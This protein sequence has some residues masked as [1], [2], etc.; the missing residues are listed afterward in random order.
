MATN[1]SALA[2]ARAFGPAQ[3][4]IGGTPLSPEA[5][6][7]TDGF[8]RACNYLAA[9]MIYLRDNPLLL[10]PLRPEH[11]KKRLLGHWGSSPGLSFVYTHLN[12]VIREYDLDM[13]FLAGPGHGAPGVLAPVY[14]EGSYSDIYPD[15]SQDLHGLQR[16]FLQ[17][18]FPGGIGSHCTPETPGSIHEGGE[19]GYSL[20]HAF[21]AA[22]DNPRLIVAVVVGDGESETG[23]LATSWHGNKFLNPARDGAV[24]PLLHLNGYKINNPTI[25]ARVPVEELASLLR[26]YGWEPLF[27]EGSEPASMHQAMAATLNHAVEEIQ[28]IQTEARR[29][30]VGVRPRWPMIVLRSPKGWTGP[31]S[32]GGHKIEGTWRAHQ[33]P[34]TEVASKPENLKQLEAWLRSYKPE[35][36]FDPDGRLAPELRDLPPQ[37]P[38][39]MG[40]NPHAN[41]G[42]LRRDLRLPDF[43]TYAVPEVK[44]GRTTAENTR[45]LGALL[46]DTLA[47]NPDNFRIFGPDENTSNKLDAAYA[48]TKKCWM[49]EG[50]PDDR[51]GT[52]LAPDG[53]V[54]EMLS[55]HT[56][57]GWF[58]GYLLTGRHG[59]FS[60]Y[61][62]FAHVID[63]MF[64]QHA[65][66]LEIASHL[67]WRADLASLNLLITSTVWR[68]DH[69]GFTHQDPG[70]L[71][72]VVNKSAQVTRI[73]LPPDANCLLSVADHC[74]R[75][76]NY[77]N[78]IVADKQK[79]LQYLDMDAAIRHCTKGVGIWEWASTDAGHDPE[80]VLAAAGDVPTKES[81]AAAALLRQEFPDVKLRFVN[82]VDL[83]R[84]QP[85]SEHPHG[86]SDRDF[87]S[88]FTS[89]RPII[90]AFH[91]YPW[92]IHRLAYRRRNH[93]NL[94]VRGYKEKGNINTPLELAMSNEVDRFSLAIDVIDRVPRLRAVGAHARERFRNQQLDCR[95]HAH[96]EGIDRPSESD[97]IWPF[98][99]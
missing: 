99:P 9:G 92:L 16:F 80:V 49:A 89:D 51:D 1:Q 19:L 24:L 34:L 29:N 73:Y 70:F 93:A 44:P 30:G 61:E 63:S 59:F 20:S 96:A 12:R 46:R 48:V 97:W 25:L 6:A 78:V 68:Q 74:L 11:L 47:A 43:R 32:V 52:E 4:T 18:S 84:L 62:A 39:R 65:K 2:G 57:E 40:S 3:S 50:L 75:S 31:A 94:H 28:R 5:L 77:V 87:D 23:P 88:L 82:V 45:P 67:P 91:G 37:G 56:L 72:L 66:W 69:N 85:E 26:G 7:R 36:L 38:R 15:R 81:L 42:L 86:L 8:W 71:D 76:R 90:F 55:E 98:A 53:R 14:L 95:A 22:F 33:V 41:G 10:E 54:M 27:V 79:H 60:T 64:N 17:F 21:G 83:F 58:E 13:I 35:E